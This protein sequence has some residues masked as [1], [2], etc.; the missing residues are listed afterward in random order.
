VIYV[1]RIQANDVDPRVKWGMTVEV[2][3]EPLD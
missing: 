3:F 1:V 2:V